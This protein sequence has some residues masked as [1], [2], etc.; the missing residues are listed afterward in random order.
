MRL[1]ESFLHCKECF[2]LKKQANILGLCLKILYVKFEIEG[3]I[4]E[5][6]KGLI[7]KSYSSSSDKF[8]CEKTA[9]LNRQQK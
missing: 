4:Y 8:V 6:P 9:G 2:S 3:L 5:D 1:N 7:F